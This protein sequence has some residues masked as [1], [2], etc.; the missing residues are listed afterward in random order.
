MITIQ[1]E[2][3]EIEHMKDQL[4]EMEKRLP[5]IMKKSINETAKMAEKKFVK[6]AK[7]TYVSNK[8]TFQDAIKTKKATVSEKASVLTSKGPA[9]ELLDF[10]VTPAG[11]FS[12]D[13]RPKEVKAK[14]KKSGSMK[15]LTKGSIKAFVTK[16]KSGHI[17]VVERVSGNETYEEGESREKRESKHLD[18]TKIRKLLSPSIPQMVFGKEAREENEGL[19]R[20]YLEEKLAQHL[21]EVMREGNSE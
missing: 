14:V 7:K 1:I 3:S 10:Q 18:I 19:I 2:E 15:S 9:K 6:R 12:G 11:V 17:A 4:G 8:E 13:D 21:D 16:F 20:E 5:K